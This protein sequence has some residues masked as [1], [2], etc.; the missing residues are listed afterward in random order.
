MR[1]YV[2]IFIGILIIVSM[3][4]SWTATPEEI[5]M[6]NAMSKKYCSMLALILIVGAIFGAPAYFEYHEEHPSIKGYFKNLGWFLKSFFV[7][8]KY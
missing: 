4:W 5:V 1:K 7:S 6:V 2:N 8:N 3:M